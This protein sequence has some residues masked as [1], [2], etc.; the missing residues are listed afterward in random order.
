MKK[1]DG[2]GRMDIY[3]KLNIRYSEMAVKKNEEKRIEKRTKV[4]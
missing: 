1:R 2:C 3:I 4:K